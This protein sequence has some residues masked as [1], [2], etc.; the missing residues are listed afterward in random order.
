MREKDLLAEIN[1]LKK[2]IEEL[3]TGK[4]YGLVWE[5]KQEKFEKDAENAVPVLKAKGGK[6]KDIALNSENDHNVLIEGD[7]YHVLSYYFQIK[8]T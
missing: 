3:K 2:I 8:V 6:F 1:R 4:P 5:D 7:N